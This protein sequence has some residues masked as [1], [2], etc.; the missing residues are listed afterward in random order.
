[1]SGV[2]MYQ[3][4]YNFD[5]TEPLNGI[6]TLFL[7]YEDAKGYSN[8]GRHAMDY[9]IAKNHDFIKNNAFELKV[10]KASP[11]RAYKFPSQE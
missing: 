9:P 6:I 5:K 8:K 4:I 10:Y 1:M 2:L 3:S 11:A 7:I